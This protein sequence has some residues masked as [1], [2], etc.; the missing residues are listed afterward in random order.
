MTAEESVHVVFDE[1]NPD[2]RDIYKNKVEEEE[3]SN[4]LLQ[5]NS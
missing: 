4:E 2:M 1:S 3:N 5:R